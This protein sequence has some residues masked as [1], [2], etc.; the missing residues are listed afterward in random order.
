MFKNSVPNSEPQTQSF[1]QPQHPILDPN[2]IGQTTEVLP[3]RRPI[4]SIQV[5]GKFDD[6][7]KINPEG[8]LGSEKNKTIQNALHSQNELRSSQNHLNCLFLMIRTR[9]LSRLV[10]K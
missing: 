1:Y 5:V 8:W 7:A 4:I 2:S 3:L 9:C 10:P 6:S